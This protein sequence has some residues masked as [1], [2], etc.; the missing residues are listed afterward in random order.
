MSEKIEKSAISIITTEKVFDKKEYYS[1]EESFSAISE[2]DEMEWSE[3]EEAK[4]RTILDIKLM[5]F[6]LAMTFVLNMDRTNICKY[7]FCL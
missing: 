3:E 1:D 5:P 6:M 2:D 4:V 7:S